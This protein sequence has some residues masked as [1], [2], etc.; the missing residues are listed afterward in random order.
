MENRH[1]GKD[2]FTISDAEQRR[3]HASALSLQCHVIASGQGMLM[4]DAIL[5]LVTSGVILLTD[6]GARLVFSANKLEIDD[7]PSPLGEE[8]LS[9]IGNSV[10]TAMLIPLVAVSYL[11]QQMTLVD[12]RQKIHACAW[13]L[14]IDCADIGLWQGIA[15]REMRGFNKAQR[16]LRSLL[17]HV[18][19][20]TS[21]WLPKLAQHPLVV[22]TPQCSG[23]QQDA[24]DVCCQWLSEF[25][26]AAQSNI[27]GIAQDCDKEYLH[28]YR[29]NLRK[30]RSVVSLLNGVYTPTAEKQIVAT[31]E[32]LMSLSGTLRDL[33]V[34][35]DKQ[36]AENNP[37]PAR[38]Q[39]S[40]EQFYAHVRTLRQQVAATVIARLNAPSTQRT[41]TK[42]ITQLQQGASPHGQKGGRPLAALGAAAVFKQLKKTHQKALKITPRSPDKQRHALR[43]ACKKLRYLSELM[44]P[45]LKIKTLSHFTKRLKVMTT[46]LG[47]FNDQHVEIEFLF[48]QKVGCADIPES[49]P[50]LGALLFIGEQRMQQARKEIDNNICEFIETLQVQLQ[51]K[52]WCTLTSRR[53]E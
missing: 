5:T 47:D 13:I 53:K 35:L 3:L 2:T 11:A 26:Q 41:F 44:L 30:A 37:L 36:T 14:S 42:L 6:D 21:D 28:R 40:A 49:L 22:Y 48:S 9:R 45:V 43:I 24:Y 34:Y 16:L 4:D 10:A 32:R 52:Y 20:T 8:P 17:A 23:A 33:D 1:L 29:I 19:L 18:Q 12:K 15:V 50:A 25:L 46:M 7:D 31:L 38:L 39:T 51:Q 27:A